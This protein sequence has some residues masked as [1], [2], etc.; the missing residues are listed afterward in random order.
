MQLWV[1]YCISKGGV[2]NVFLRNETFF[3]LPFKGNKKRR[4]T[5]KE[6]YAIYV[7]K[8][9]N[10]ITPTP[11]SPPR[12]C[13]SWTPSSTTSLSASRHPVRPLAYCTKTSGWPL[14]SPLYRKPTLFKDHNPNIR[15]LPFW[16]PRGITDI[17]LYIY[18]YCMYI[19]I[20]YITPVYYS[21][22]SLSGIE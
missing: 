10:E 18:I 9:L 7:Y 16:C 11:A 22:N 2:I 4:K 19:Y 14:T 21:D 15:T 13:E 5:R 3:L 20:L 6:S 17:G 12:R 8:V 1:T